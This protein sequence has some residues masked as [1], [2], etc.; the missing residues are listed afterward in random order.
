[1]TWY[2]GLMDLIF[3]CWLSYTYLFV[4]YRCKKQKIKRKDRNEFCSKNATPRHN[5]CTSWFYV[6]TVCLCCQVEYFVIIIYSLGAFVARSII[7]LVIRYLLCY[8][9]AS[10]LIL[11]LLDIYFVFLLPCWL[12]CLLLDIYFLS[13]FPSWLFCLLLYIYVV[14]IFVIIDYWLYWR[15]VLLD[16]QLF[17]IHCVCVVPLPCELCVWI[18]AVYTRSR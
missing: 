11:L 12:F 14:V 7:L 15:F 17:A 5:A 18:F 1:M 8:C 10:L 13:L 6:F 16:C 9:V 3:C 4:I 2:K